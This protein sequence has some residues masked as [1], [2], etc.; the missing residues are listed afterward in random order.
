MGF[1]IVSLRL[2]ALGLGFDFQVW[3]SSVVDC[4]GLYCLEAAA[5]SSALGAAVKSKA[6]PATKS[7]SKAA[8]LGKLLLRAGFRV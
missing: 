6:S 7:K 8:E 3:G 5:S 4:S 2:R 1:G